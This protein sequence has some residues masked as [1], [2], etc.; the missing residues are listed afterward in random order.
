MKVICTAE[1]YGFGPVSK[2]T[3]IAKLLKKK[4]SVHLVFVG[5]HAAYDFASRS[6]IFDECY[7]SEPSSITA[8]HLIANSDYVM[9]VMESYSI[10]YAKQYNKKSFFIDSLFW[11]WDLK[12]STSYYVNM[13][14]SIEE[15]PVDHTNRFKSKTPHE[16]E[17]LAHLLTTMSFV[18]NF[19]GVEKRLKEF[20]RY[21]QMTKVGALID[22]N[23]KGKLKKEYKIL[24]ACGGLKTPM[25]SV[26]DNKTYVQIIGKIIN[27]I[28][29]NPCFRKYKIVVA[30]ND[31]F[32]SKNLFLQ[33]FNKE[34]EV[35]FF[36]H[37]DFLHELSSSFVLF[38]S[39]G[40]TTM[41]E[42]MAYGIPIFL[43]PEQSYG[44][45]HIYHKLKKTGLR[46]PNLIL[47]ELKVR[48]THNDPVVETKH[49][50]KQIRTYLDD[51]MLIDVMRKTATDF[52]KKLENQYFYDKIL[53]KQEKILHRLGGVNGS[54]IVATKISKVMM[55]K[56]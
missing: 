32:I 19:P 11:L 24:V 20:V 55:G 26:S 8:K 35:K 37:D 50:Y 34:V 1:A 54:E 51:Y 42:G 25:V 4:I 49:I 33:Y 12:R 15:N 18:Q 14:Y 31:N 5:K 13:A 21:T 40:I 46:F 9:S 56:I 22:L 53:E 17:Y 43:L 28:A 52:I 44:Q 41:Y 39:P 2:L 30:L 29:M 27:G 10:L 38:T 6:D 48:K 23:Y 3:S 45:Y 36:S 47:K 16:Q 7:N